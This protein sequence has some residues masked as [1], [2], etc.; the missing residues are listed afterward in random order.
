MQI[1]NPLRGRSAKNGTSSRVAR[2]LPKARHE[3]GLLLVGVFK[4]SKA[5]FF[6]AVGAGA[7][8]LVNRNMDDVLM[9]IIDALRIDPERRFVG[10]LLEQAG[11]VNSHQLR[12]AGMLSFLYAVVCVVEGTGLVLEKSW[13]E[14]F[15]VILTAMG[16]PWE[17]YSLME[18]FSP[19]KVVLILI[20]MAVLLYLLWILKK[21][22]Q[23]EAM[24]TE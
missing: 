14:Y 7:L 16:L 18:K 22:K 11:L 17:S 19:Y 1:K 15:T 23:G 10:I 24:A 12:R 6:T 9:R 20:N 4:L 5:I 8:Q 13:A 21:K 3:R 2:G